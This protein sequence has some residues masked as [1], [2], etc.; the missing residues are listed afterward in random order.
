MKT[1][2]ILW[3]NLLL[4]EKVRAKEAHTA[5]SLFC[6]HRRVYQKLPPL[7][8][9]QQTPPRVKGQQS[10]RLRGKHNVPRMWLKKKKRA[11]EIRVCDFLL[12]LCHFPSAPEKKRLVDT[13]PEFS[14]SVSSNNV[15]TSTTK[16]TTS[17]VLFYTKCY[18]S[19]RHPDYPRLLIT[20][21]KVL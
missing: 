16:Y 10:Q 14:S 1:E 5:L 20:K 13:G 17:F 9:Y 6:K 12:R 7:W 18:Q 21:E 15:N 3:F 4:E 2:S 11:G 8:F 19:K